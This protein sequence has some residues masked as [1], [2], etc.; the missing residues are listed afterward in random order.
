MGV[1][2]LGAAYGAFFTTVF[3]FGLFVVYGARHESFRRLISPGPSFL[4]ARN[5][6]PWIPVGL[7]L[8][9]S[10]MGN[11][12]LF[13]P[14]VAGAMY[15]WAGVVGY[16]LSSTVPYVLLMWLSP[17]VYKTTKGGFCSCDHIA[18]RFGLLA[19]MAAAAVSL[20]MMFVTLSSELTTVGMSMSALSSNAFPLPCAVILVAAV[21]LL[22][23]LLGG[24]KCCIISDVVQALVIVFLFVPFVIYLICTGTALEDS[25]GVP[26]RVSNSFINKESVVAGAVFVLSVWPI[27]LCDQGIWQR[28]WA[29]RSVSDM[30]KGFLFAGVLAGVSVFLFGVAGIVCLTA[31]EAVNGGSLFTY[32]AAHLPVPWVVVLCVLV[33]ACVTS[34]VDTY[35]AAIVSLIGKDL[36]RYNLSFNWAR[37]AMALINIPAV[38]LAL[39]QVPLMSLFMVSNIL[40]SVLSGPFLVSVHPKL[41]SFGFLGGLACALVTLVLC[42]LVTAAATDTP[43]SFSFFAPDDISTVPYVICF[44]VV[45]A[46]GA[47]AAAAI[48]AIQ[49]RFREGTAPGVATPETG[50]NDIQGN[51]YAAMTKLG[52]SAEQQRQQKNSS[53]SDSSSNSGQG[54]SPV[55]QQPSPNETRE[56]FCS[57]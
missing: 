1:L 28:V 43:F 10:F 17:L 50:T 56:L 8:Y 15:S 6:I 9:A 24:L 25:L 30:K 7:S 51:P 32:A 48:S 46:V 41:T 42:G 2:D 16:A 53:I 34:S 47:G 39:Y 57:A 29:A 4:S 22:Y 12:V 38:L 5:E 44:T 54:G 13:L 11:W 40:C 20:S 49:W 35:Q 31:D 18:V 45:P 3:G 37:A 27:F 26:Q 21:P 55:C 52:D 14:P 19:Q 36:E 23:V 33:L